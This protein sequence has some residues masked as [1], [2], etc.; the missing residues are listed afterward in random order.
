MTVQVDLC[1]TWSETPKTGFLA[2]WLICKLKSNK[3]LELV[4]KQLGVGKQSGVGKQLEIV[5]MLNETTL[6]K[7]IRV[8]RRLSRK[9][10]DTID[11]FNRKRNAVSVNISGFA[12][13][14]HEQIDDF[15]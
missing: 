6:Q 4:G 2:S 14:F 9:F 10:V 11:I 15:L 8:I 5:L 12:K 13:I 7:H 1:R 3:E